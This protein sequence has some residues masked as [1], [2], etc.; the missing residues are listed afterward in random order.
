M[1]GC[2]TLETAAL[3]VRSTVVYIYKKP[4]YTLRRRSGCVMVIAGSLS[5]SSSGRIYLMHASTRVKLS[6]GQCGQWPTVLG[7][8]HRCLRKKKK[9][10]NMITYH[11]MCMLPLAFLS[12][13]TSII[14]PQNWRK[15]LSHWR[16]F[17]F[18]NICLN[19][20]SLLP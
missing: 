5:Q 3:C 18:F 9:M 10:I 2:H 1:Y 19:W 7:M 11:N 16:K 4:S 13:D 15:H 20:F 8:T 6:N 17:C 12:T 14:L